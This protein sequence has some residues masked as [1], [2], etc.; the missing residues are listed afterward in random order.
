MLW[1]IYIILLS[2]ICF[3][4]P[5]LYAENIKIPISSWLNKAINDANHKLQKDIAH[6]SKLIG[7]TKEEYEKSVKKDDERCAKGKEAILH[8]LKVCLSFEPRFHLDCSMEQDYLSEHKRLCRI[9]AVLLYKNYAKETAFQKDEIRKSKLRSE[10]NL[11]YEINRERK[12][13]QKK[14]I[15]KRNSLPLH[16]LL[17]I[18]RQYVKQKINVTR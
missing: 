2:G 3:Y 16:S 4:C 9:N 12:R 8:S 6:H 15:K 11:K 7:D 17:M 5:S 10:N 1:K 18:V 14:G 13:R